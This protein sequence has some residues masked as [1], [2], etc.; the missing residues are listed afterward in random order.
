[1]ISASGSI[2]PGL[3]NTVSATCTGSKMPVGGGHT[4][5][6]APLAGNSIEIRASRPQGLI[7]GDGFPG[8]RVVAKN[9]DTSALALTVYAICVNAPTGSSIR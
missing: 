5:V 8:W 6:V 3:V 1:M 7:A 2:N 9:T 4:D